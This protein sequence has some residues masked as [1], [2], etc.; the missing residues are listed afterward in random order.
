[1][2]NLAERYARVTCTKCEGQGKQ[3]ADVFERVS[4]SIGVQITRQTIDC[5]HCKGTGYIINKEYL[6]VANEALGARRSLAQEICEGLK[7]RG[8]WV[9]TDLDSAD[10]INAVFQA[11]EKAKA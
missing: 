10:V 4:T 1:M 11:L 5:V 7:T 2:A 3:V 9:P 6:R 8:Y